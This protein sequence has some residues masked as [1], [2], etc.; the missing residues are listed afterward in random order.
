M[1]YLQLYHSHIHI[2]QHILIYMYM[3]SYPTVKPIIIVLMTGL[4]GTHR[5]NAQIPPLKSRAQQTQG[6]RCKS[7][8]G[9]LGPSKPQSQC[10]NPTFR[11]QGLASHKVVGS[12]PALEIHLIFSSYITCMWS[13]VT[14]HST[15]YIK[16]HC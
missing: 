13:V 8:L 5:V 3:Y 16:C 9:N 2:S 11:I 12:N 14:I 4:V 6:C 7:C 1:C 10:S 15:I